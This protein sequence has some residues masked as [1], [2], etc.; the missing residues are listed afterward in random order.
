MERM[1]ELV[2]L[3]N[4]AAEAYYLGSPFMTDFEYDQL[5]DELSTLETQ[6]NTVL[7]NSPTQKVGAEI[8]G[9]R[10]KIKHAIPALSLGK[11]KD[12]EEL[13]RWLGDKEGILSW[14]MDGLTL[15]LTYKNGL[16]YSAVTRGNG[17][18]GENVMDAV[19]YIEGISPTIP[20]LSDVIIRGEVVM[21][22]DEFER[23]N[24]QAQ[25][26]DEKYKNARNLAAGTL[27]ALD[28]LVHQTRRL[29]F[30]AF[31]VEFTGYRM[32][33][34]ADAMEYLKSLG[35][36]IVTFMR[37]NKDTLLSR[38]DLF[39][40]AISHNHFPSDGLV[41]TYNDIEYG[42]SLGLTGHHPRHSIAFKWKDECQDT[43]M[44]E[45]VWSPS[46]TGLLNPV[47]VFKP[48]EIDGTTVS[49]ASVH[50]VSIFKKLR[51]GKGDIV[52][53]YKANMI[54]PQIAENKTPSHSFEVPEKCPVCGSA[55]RIHQNV[56]S[57]EEII[58]TLYCENPYCKCKLL[59]KLEFFTTRNAMNI[60]G[61]SDK[62]IEQLYHCGWLES[63]SDFYKLHAHENEM[64]VLPGMGEI[65]VSNIL[66][67]IEKSKK[68]DLRH[69]ITA[70][71][72]PMIGKDTASLI[73]DYCNNSI[74]EFKLLLENQAIQSKICEVNGIGDVAI[75][76][77]DKWF[78]VKENRDDFYSLLTYLEFAMP[79]IKGSKLS[80]KT[81]V[82][83]GTLNHFE[84]RDALC[85]LIVENGGKT[86]GSV[87]KN[88][89][90]LINNDVSSTSGKNKKAKELN[91]PI[92]SEEEFL[93]MLK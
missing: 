16:L 87:S 76:S 19:P 51:L 68:T 79:D 4:K 85:N 42:I 36:G 41:L 30:F 74:N 88:T 60:E 48:V 58:E 9:T 91:I 8:S 77:L 66:K 70:L 33:N 34:Y 56:S 24:N 84:N 18:I 73:A 92:I 31:N 81:F 6:M 57:N 26:P 25:T 80:G 43:T 82:I 52:S 62:T 32:T 21:S 49:R 78:L 61:V 45:V 44:E 86:S 53:V 54:I 75:N 17:Y 40:K 38:I 72:I 50:N 83:T 65:T 1:K 12:R 29:N 63:F 11:T 55:T 37:C 3:L 89:S 13:K 10:E 23:I 15:V 39:E 22:Y 5:F 64:K 7:P 35:F 59:G 20:I 90:Y 69:F 47:A 67:A 93:E 71:S 28:I 2:E 27:R 46:K 14:K